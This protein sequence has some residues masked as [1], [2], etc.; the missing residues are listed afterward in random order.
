MADFPVPVGPTKRS[1]LLWETYV[2]RKNF[3]RTVSTVGM[4][5]SFT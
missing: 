5:K 2:S 4:I 1:G 3:C